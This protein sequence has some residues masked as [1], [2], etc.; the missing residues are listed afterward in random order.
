MAELKLSAT[1]GGAAGGVVVL[2]GTTDTGYAVL[3]E[4]GWGSYVVDPVTAVNQAG[5]GVAAGGNVRQRV[6][7]IPVRFRAASKSAVVLLVQNLGREV[8]ALA[9]SGGELRWKSNNATYPSYLK[10]QAATLE[11]PQEWQWEVH[12]RTDGMLTL[13]CDAAFLGDDLAIYEDFGPRVDG[14]SPL[15]ADFTLD[16]GAGTLSIGVISDVVRPRS[17]L[18]PSSTAAK[19]FRH[20]GRG[21]TYQDAAVTWSIR[22]GASAAALNFGCGILDSS[23]NGLV[24]RIVGA[25]TNQIQVCTV[26][27]GTPTAIAT[28]AFAPAANTTYW[29][30]FRR[31]GAKVFAQVFSTPPGLSTVAAAETSISLTAAQQQANPGTHPAGMVTPVAT[32]ERYHAFDVR[33]YTY[34]HNAPETLRLTGIPGDLPAL[35][36]FEF[37]QPAAFATQLLWGMI[38]WDDRARDPNMVWNGGGADN[39]AVA[40]AGGWAIAAETNM[41]AV[42]TSVT[43]QTSTARYG[44][45]CLEIVSTAAADSGA[46]FRVHRRF[47]QGR[48]Y[49]AFGWLQSAAGVGNA[50]IRF[51]NG[52]ATDRASS[53]PVGLT[54]SFVLHSCVW[55]PSADR[56]MA[57]FHFNHSTASVETFR[58]DGGQVYEASPVTLS[59]AISS[60]GATTCTTT[61]PPPE[62]W[63]W[64]KARLAGGQVVAL[65]DSEIVRIIA[66]D[67]STNTLTIDR[68]FDGSTAATHVINSVAYLLDLYT[69]HLDGV[70]FCGGVDVAGAASPWYESPTTSTENTSDAQ[71]RSGY[72]ISTTTA[73][74]SQVWSYLIDPA[75]LT[76]DDYE[77]DRVLLE[78]WGRFAYDASLPNLR[79]TLLTAG[80]DSVSGAAYDLETGSAGLPHS[81]SS[82]SVWRFSRLGLVAVKYAD[83]AARRRQ[84]LQITPSWTSTGFGFALEEIILTRPKRRIMLPTGL[85]NQ[86]RYPVLMAAASTQ[87]TRRVYSDLTS[88]ALGVNSQIGEHQPK[89]SGSPLGGFLTAQAITLPTPNA[90]VL[91]KVSSHIPNQPTAPGANESPFAQQ[92]GFAVNV[93]PRFKTIR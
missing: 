89:G 62:G 63:E 12:N 77:N 46:T 92:F 59:A 11:V 76:P 39:A 7:T 68:G 18:V 64:Y 70:H 21:Y 60:A 35:A 79:V 74:T 4:P 61:A 41:S 28:A 69:P 8:E 81:T 51:G 3:R 23:G 80:D 52:P 78:V 88:E 13:W 34:L 67:A 19:R 58:G 25:A 26:A 48:P 66:I 53:T 37:A 75:T 16:A 6:V 31:E 29:V 5:L 44:N 90:D 40:G 87:I 14:T 36:E 50:Y 45:S 73:V 84:Q 65:V 85:D 86:P 49:V 20:T 57:T 71:G 2:N 17:A 24:A 22:T 33:P 32:D 55:T 82:S 47:K 43:R 1:R 56:D 91:V 10:V 72:K 38:A 42:C 9:R 93:R 54:T 30:R 15:T 83:I 27:A